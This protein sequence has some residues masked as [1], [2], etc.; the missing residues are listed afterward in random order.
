MNLKK[1]I[2]VSGFAAIAIGGGM[3]GASISTASADETNEG[4]EVMTRGPVHEAFAETVVFD[5]I[6]GIIVSLQPPALI[7]EVMPDQRPTGDNVAWIPGYWGWDEDR[8]DFLWISGIWRNLP[9]GR[10]WIPGYWSTVDTGHQWTSGYWQDAEADEVTYL[11]EPPRSVE[12]GPNIA[13]SSDDQTW[14]PGSWQYR[15]NRYAWRAGSWVTARPNWCWTPSYYRWAPRGYVYVDGYWDYPVINRGVVFAPVHF[16]RA[17]CERPDFYYSPHTVVSLSVF[18]NHLFLRPNYGHYYFGD[19]YEPRYRDH[20]YASYS[21]GARYRGYDPIYSHSRWENRHDRDWD[22]QRQD[23]YEHRRDNADARPPRTWAALNDR[24][25]RG[26]DRGDYA[27][28]ERYDRITDSRKDG[29]SGFQKVSDDERQR[30]VSQKNEIRNY[31]R[32]RQQREVS[33]GRVRDDQQGQ[34]QASREKASRSP[35]VGRQ[36]DRSEKNGGPPERLQKRTSEK[37]EIASRETRNGD[38]SQGGSNDRESAKTASRQDDKRGGNDV[39]QNRSEP[40]RESRTMPGQRREAETSGRSNSIAGGGREIERQAKP[41]SKDVLVPK[42]DVDPGARSDDKQRASS[43]RQPAER[44]TDVPNVQRREQSSQ[45]RQA[46][47]QTERRSTQPE[48]RS[49]S[50]QEAPNRKANP[51]PTRESIPQAAPQRTQSSPRQQAQPQRTQPTRPDQRQAQPVPQRQQASP[52]RSEPR[53]QQAE[54]QRQQARPQQRQSERAPERQQAAPQRVQP[55]PQQVAPQRQQVER[56]PQ[57]Q[58]SAPQ[59]VQ[60]RPQQAAPQR[61]Q[62]SRPEPRQ[63]QAAP[64]RQSQAPQQRETSRPQAETRSSS[65]TESSEERK[66]E[67]KRR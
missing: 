29:R 11:P 5:P 19:Y 66:S 22:R 61:Q 2:F 42:R 18:S 60:P 38:Q 3:F 32:E 24:R 35:L 63:M 9:P 54:P 44:R 6:P 10:E 50:R 28:A 30:F 64:Q 1:C 8:N 7:E 55:R 17:Y 36:S 40:N 26:G 43:E 57:R 52:Q 15:E 39:G 62:A 20:Y 41:A 53:R 21:Y 59:R 49:P 33:S 67:G 31:S 16:Q 56:A 13:A 46:T 47:P 27:T 37:S 12:A 45:P 14:I 23:Y 34:S 51:S 25:E 65:R 48:L 4:M 58:Q